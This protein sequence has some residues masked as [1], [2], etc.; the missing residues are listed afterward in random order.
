MQRAL[1]GFIG[2][3]VVA[4]AACGGKVVAD[5]A[6]GNGGAGGGS[7]GAGGTSNSGTTNNSGTGGIPASTS[8]FPSSG[9]VSPVGPSSV[10]SAVSTGGNDVC[11][12][13]CG[14]WGAMCGVNNCLANCQQAVQG[15]CAMAFTAGILC[16]QQNGGAGCGN[17]PPECEK[18][19]GAYQMCSLPNGCN[20][21]MCGGGPNGA[22]TCAGA[23][24]NK[25]LEADCNGN[26]CVC[27]ENGTPVG[28]CQSNAPPGTLPCDVLDGCCGTFFSIGG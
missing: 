18:D 26:L 23:C 5:G 4:A 3:V 10:V 19:F 27:L 25:K 13:F 14:T 8:T 1:L 22:C 9:D 15:P 11:M 24:G 2:I 6:Q 20:A 7:G 16:L 28:K 21:L 17:I 12:Q